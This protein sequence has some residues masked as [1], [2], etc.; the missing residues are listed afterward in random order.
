[1]LAALMDCRGRVL[2]RKELTRRAG[3]SDVNQR[4]C[5]S[6]LVNVRRALGPDSI[7]TVRGRGWI[8][9]PDF[10]ERARRLIEK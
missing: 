5:D 4:R 1:M 6:L 10:E 9:S 2:G 3:L 7:R 8:L